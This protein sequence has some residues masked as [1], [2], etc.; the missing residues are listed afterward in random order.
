MNTT[1]LTYREYIYSL[2][3]QM[4]L[5]I[6]KLDHIFYSDLLKLFSKVLLREAANKVPFLVALIGGIR[7]GH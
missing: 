2:W 4:M 3:L 7:P 6:Q 1:N 5:I